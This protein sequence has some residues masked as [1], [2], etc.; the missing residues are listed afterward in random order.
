MAPV[1]VGLRVV[2]DWCAMWPGEPLCWVG[3]SIGGIAGF[4]VAYPVN[5]WMVGRGMK[6]GL[7]TE[8]KENEEGNA[9]KAPS[10]KAG[11]N[12]GKRGAQPSTGSTGGDS[13]ETAPMPGMDP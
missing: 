10:T 9:T 7:M 6:H 5:V 2:R 8:R 12:A 11:A 3:M 13:A 1:V 4:A